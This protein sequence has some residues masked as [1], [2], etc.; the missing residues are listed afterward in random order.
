MKEYGYMLSV[1]NKENLFEFVVHD[2]DDLY[3]FRRMS[4]VMDDLFKRGK[5]KGTILG[6]ISF[7][8][9]TID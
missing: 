4:S 3:R 2:F 1:I 9:S 5:I 8:K 7:L 6:F